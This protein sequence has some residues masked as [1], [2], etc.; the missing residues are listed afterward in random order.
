M[1]VQIKEILAEQTYALRHPLLRQGQPYES[2]RLDQDNHPQT[3]HLGAYV[4]HRL[5]GI[6]SAMPNRCPE[7]INQNAIQL[8]GIAVDPE[9]QRN[10][11]A[12]QLI[13]SILLRIQANK[14]VHCVWLNSRVKANAL[15]LSN[16]FEV[17]GTP[18]EIIPIGMHQR[19]IQ[20]M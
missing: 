10:K 2:C 4:S 13:Q 16:G 11:I 5:V 18:F 9:F 19:F 7:F 8:R 15:Y 20:W 14:S 1:E 12:S 6:L 17:L 3:L